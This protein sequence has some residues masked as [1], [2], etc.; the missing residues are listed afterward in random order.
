M[1]T[2]LTSPIRPQNPVNDSYFEKAI[3]SVNGNLEMKESMK[4]LY[5]ADQQAKYLC[6]QA[7]VKTLLQQLQ[8]LKQ[9]RLTDGA[10]PRE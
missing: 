9:Q 3:T 6:L 7:E 5:Q 1:S 2:L 8:V 4:S 10:S